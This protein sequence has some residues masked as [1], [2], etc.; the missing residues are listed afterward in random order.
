MK[1]L[2]KVLA[3]LVVF[4]MVVSTVAFASFT[5]VADTSSYATAIDVGVDLGIIK[6][7]DD[8]TFRPEGEI[9][10]A[11]FAAIVVRLLGQ[12]AQAAGA[13][14]STQFADV[15]ANHWAAGYVNIA[16]QAGVINGYGNGNFGP[17]DLVAYQDALTMM[18]RALGYEPAIGSAGYPTGYLTKAGDL[19]L[20]KNVNGT[21]GVPANRATVAQIAFNAL[22]VPLMTQSGYGTFTQFVINDGYS[23]TTGTSNVKKTLLSE[24]HSTVKIQ[25]EILSST[26]STSSSTTISEKVEVLITDG[27]RNK[28]G[29]GAGQ[30]WN[31]EVGSS[32]AL[33]YVGKKCVMFVEYD[34]FNTTCTVKAIYETEVDSIVINLSDVETFTRPTSTPVYGDVDED[35]VAGNDGNDD[36]DPSTQ[37]PQQ[38]ISYNRTNGLV[39]TEDFD[40]TI[41]AG[42]A[43]YY[44][45]VALSDLKANVYVGDSLVLKKSGTIEL[46]LLDTSTTTA[47]YDTV[48][49]TANDVV[50]VDNVRDSASRV[51][52]KAASHNQLKTFS[53]DETDG[54]VKAT[55]VDA[56]GAAM[57]WADL[58]EFDVI[59]VN[60]VATNAKAIIKAQVINNTVTGTVTEVDESANW[61]TNP[62]AATAYKYVW[63]DDTE[64]EVKAFAENDKEIKVGDEGTYYLSDSGIVWHEATVSVNTNYAYV[65]AADNES[66][67]DSARIKMVTADGIATYDVNSKIYVTELN[68]NGGNKYERSTNKLAVNGVAFDLDTIENTLITYKTD[69]NGAITAI[70]VALTAGTINPV[71]NQAYD[72][73]DYFTIHNSGNSLT[74]NNYDPDD[75]SF[76][77]RYTLTEDTVVFDVTDVNDNTNW[78]VVALKNLAEGDS[79]AGAYI[80]NVDDDDNIG[81]IVV[82]SAQGTNISGATNAATFVTGISEAYDEDGVLVDYVKGYVNGEEVVYV[83]DGVTLPTIGSLVIP[84]YKSNG[85]VKN[86]KTIVNGYQGGVQNSNNEANG[87]AGS[88]TYVSAGNYTGTLTSQD[89]AKGRIVINGTTHKIPA[90]ANVYVYDSTSNARVKYEVNSY[91]G[92]VEYDDPAKSGTG[93]WVL[94]DKYTV[95]KSVDVTLYEYDGD[96]VD[97][98][99][100]VK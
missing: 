85:D 59:G 55:L 88:A 87:Y 90:T 99:Y 10:R 16:V 24:N 79:L 54:K 89:S 4:M 14:A 22:D 100:Y 11:E 2:N 70:E 76:N 23:S 8:N 13:A 78:E 74:L 96:I 29:I 46:A 21:N 1:N 20:T 91:V 63:I 40:Y 71:N 69:A 67:M 84:E 56:N 52:T 33:D 60:Y 61:A 49:I 94:D 93:N 3:M 44:N 50:V 9:T 15:P 51:S 36:G 28:F 95:A 82:T 26:D 66:G 98:V 77:N 7:Y 92:R 37:D 45:G 43:V 58:E 48:Y 73:E 31:M 32:D 30:I 12:E 57:D 80:Y 83:S 42:A 41:A 17:D 62:Y 68:I 5:D 81:A 18:V 75:Y 39:K 72:S 64:Y 65:I 19:G 38:I 27:L 25:G 34:E 6:G 86:Y 53:Y 47:D 97:V 35:G